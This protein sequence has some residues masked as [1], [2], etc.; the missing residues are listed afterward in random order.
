[1]TNQLNLSDYFK[2]ISFEEVEIRKHIITDISKLMSEKIK[3]NDKQNRSLEKIL[4]NTLDGFKKKLALHLILNEDENIYETFDVKKVDNC[5]INGSKVTSCYINKI[6]HES[7]SI[8]ISIPYKEEFY[9]DSLRLVYVDKEN[10]LYYY[11]GEILLKYINNK[12]I[13]SYECKNG[14]MFYKIFIDCLYKKKN[15]DVLLYQNDNN[16]YIINH[17]DIKQEYINKCKEFSEKTLDTL[18]HAYKGKLNELAYY[19]AYMIP[20]DLD[21]MFKINGPDSYDVINN[22]IKIDITSF[23]LKKN[24]HDYI[25]IYLSKNKYESIIKRLE[26]SVFGSGNYNIDAIAFVEHINDNYYIL[27][28]H[29]EI[30][31]FLELNSCKQKEKDNYIYLS[32]YKNKFKYI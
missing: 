5:K 19:N 8:S 24:E 26:S 1:M 20:V 14:K 9:K 29:Y 7:N 23:K 3:I 6:N 2:Y 25:G 30:N 32:L 18:K 16:I 10:N 28:N 13:R 4:D 17:S 15:N 21:F 11:I 12:E 27:R 31:N 22:N